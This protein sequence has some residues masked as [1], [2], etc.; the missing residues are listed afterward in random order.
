M[1]RPKGTIVQVGLMG[2]GKV[3]VNVGLL[4][5]KRARWIGTTLRGR[6]LEEKA[7]ICRRFAE[8]VLPL[9]TSG[10][11]RPVVD[12]RFAL[13]QVAAAHERMEADANV[14]KILLDMR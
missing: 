2:G 7:S 1:L 11:L 3:E 4:L 14:G 12:T 9:F 8:E 5:M 13:D 6:P 10:Q